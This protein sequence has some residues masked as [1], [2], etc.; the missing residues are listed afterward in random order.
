MRCD[1]SFW[2][3]KLLRMRITVIEH[4]ADAPL[5]YLGGWL[6]PVCDVVRPYLGEEV[7]SRAADGLITEVEFRA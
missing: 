3:D 7:P 1:E 6:G 4:E 2:A 5:G